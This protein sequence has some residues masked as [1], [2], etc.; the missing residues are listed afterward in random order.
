SQ[1]SL[2]QQ[3]EEEEEE[4]EQEIEEVEEEEVEGDKPS[5]EEILRPTSAPINICAGL[6]ARDE[7]M[8]EVLSQSGT[9]YFTVAQDLMSFRADDE[10]PM[11]PLKST[12]FYSARR[13]RH[14]SEASEALDNHEQRA[15]SGWRTAEER[16]ATGTHSS[17]S[18]LQ[19]LQERELAAAT[20]TVEPLQEEVKEEHSKGGLVVVSQQ[21]LM[22]KRSQ[23]SFVTRT[24]TPLKIRTRTSSSTLRCREKL[25]NDETVST[26][27]PLTEEGFC[28]F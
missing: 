25:G 24:R 23:E 21:Q 16:L 15:L 4:E 9:S 8:S 11:T 6:A 20:A 14:G 2:Y 13:Y 5:L 18:L 7:A 27:S 22:G 1:L 12:D 3:E 26:Y 19:P 10:P 17:F 28:Y